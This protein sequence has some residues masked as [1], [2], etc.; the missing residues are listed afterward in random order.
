MITPL[1]QQ[2]REAASSPSDNA[3]ERAL[4]REAADSAYAVVEPLLRDIFDTWDD[5]HCYV[6]LDA[7]MIMSAAIRR[8]R[9]ALGE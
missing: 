7:Y 5:V 4:A 1:Q 2:M 6:A 3:D 8:A 9:E